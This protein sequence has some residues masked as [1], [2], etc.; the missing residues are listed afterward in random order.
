LGLNQPSLSAGTPCAGGRH[1]TTNNV[2]ELL[3]VIALRKSV[4]GFVRL[5][6][7]SNMAEVCK[8][9]DFLGFCRSWQ[10]DKEQV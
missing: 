6:P 9:K 10:G 3:A 4:L 7:D 8:P 2:V 1:H 5:Y